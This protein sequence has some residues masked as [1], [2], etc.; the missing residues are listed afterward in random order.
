MTPRP[1]SKQAF[2]QR[3]TRKGALGGFIVII[4]L[5][6]PVPPGANSA[7]AAMIW[8]S[9]LSLMLGAFLALPASTAP[10]QAGRH[11]AVFLLCGVAMTFALMQTVP[12]GFAS[13]LPRAIPRPDT[14]SLVP[15]ASRQGVLRLISFAI[16]FALTLEICTGGQRIRHMR[17]LLFTG[18]ALHALAALAMLNL[19]GDSALWGEKPAYA[20]FATGSFVN[21]NAFATYLG[22]GL[23]LG[24]SIILEDEHRRMMPRAVLLPGLFV[25]VIAL[26]STG[27]RMGVVASLSAAIVCITL[28]KG[29][30][31]LRWIALTLGLALACFLIFGQ[32]LAERALHTGHSLN[33]RMI[34]WRQVGAMIADRPLAGFGLNSFAP[35]FQLYHRPPLSSGVTWDHAHSTYLTWWVELG[36]IAGSLPM[37]AI[38]LAGRR[39]AKSLHAHPYGR[40]PGAAGVS[41]LILGVTH[42]LVDFSLEVLPTTFLFVTLI[43]MGMSRP[44]LPDKPA[45]EE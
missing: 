7:L 15:Q 10:L 22:M 45:S 14:I 38:G 26:L 1:A 43:A 37:V 24:L 36:V 6:S 20:G 35:A 33:T 30:R 28:M 32:S 13:P 11:R 23:V 16:L 12:L 31:S 44:T 2:F 39:T 19:F 8:T 29:A 21:R 41:A 40:G 42:S 25:I 9:L 4:V 3:A 34:L 27:S 5:V 18:V 17:W